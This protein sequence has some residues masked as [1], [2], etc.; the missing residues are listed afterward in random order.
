[1]RT[2]ATQH[3]KTQLGMPSLHPPAGRPSPAT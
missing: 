3:T 1:M 2:Q